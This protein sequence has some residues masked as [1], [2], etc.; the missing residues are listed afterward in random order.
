[1]LVRY[2]ILCSVDEFESINAS[3]TPAESASSSLGKRKVSNLSDPIG[4]S[5]SRKFKRPT[6]VDNPEVFREKPYFIVCHSY[7]NKYLLTNYNLRL[8]L[9]PSSVISEVLISVAG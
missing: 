6:A 9:L 4:P 2:F 5:K 8:I 3:S 1:M 7:L